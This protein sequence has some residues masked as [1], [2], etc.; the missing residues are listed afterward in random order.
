[1]NL[2]R[3]T[4]HTVKNYPA[5]PLKKEKSNIMISRGGRRGYDVR[6]TTYDGEKQKS[7]GAI[8]IK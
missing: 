6:R 7:R 4:H 3:R 8:K 1:M 2:H 5:T